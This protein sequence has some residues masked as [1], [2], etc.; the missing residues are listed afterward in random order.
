MNKNIDIFNNIIGK[1]NKVVYVKNHKEHNVFL[2]KYNPNLKIKGNNNK[3]TFINHQKRTLFFPKGIN[4]SINGNNNNLILYVSDFE[5]FRIN[6]WYDDNS[7][8]IDEQNLQKVSD[9]FVGIAHGATV[10]IGRDCELG[11]GDLHIVAN[12]DYINKHKLVIGNNVHI[13]KDVII[14]TSD[15]QTLIDLLT[16]TPI[17][18]PEDVIIEDNVWIMSR[19]IILKGSYISKGSA[20][21]AYSLLNKKFYEK[22][23]LLCGTPAKCIKTNITWS[24]LPYG[25][26][27]HKI[28]NK[29]V[30]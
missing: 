4:I 16:N 21:G 25:D 18:E 14:R 5:N 7:F 2:S 23:I 19:C 1:N 28:N 8:V 6:I 20:L 17:S 12:S 30:R 13:A 11:N 26:Y 29:G 27:M 3:I 24:V 10:K 15:G 22:N 9:V